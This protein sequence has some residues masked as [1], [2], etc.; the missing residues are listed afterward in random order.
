MDDILDKAGLPTRFPA[1]IDNHRF[2]DLMAVDKKV[3]AGRIR[4][5]LLKKLGEAVITDEF[6]PALL[7]ATL[8]AHRSVEA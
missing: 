5:V 3:E 7:E 2:L 8:N 4:L 6:D 1:S